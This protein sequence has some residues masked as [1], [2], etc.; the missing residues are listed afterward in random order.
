[1]S[2]H[3]RSPVW[4]ASRKAGLAALL[5]LQFAAAYAIGSGE[6][7]A[8]HQSSLFAPIAVTAFTPVALFLAA[9]GLSARFRGFVLAQD[10]RRITQMQQWRVVGFV[11]LALFAFEVLPGLFA[12]PAGVGDVAVGLMAL[13]VVARLERDPGF[14]TSAGFVGFHLLGLL[15]FTVAIVTAGL[16]AGAYPELISGG[17]TSAPMDVWPLN[18]F[19]S[20]IVPGFII[21]HLTALLKVRELRRVVREPA[22]GRLQAA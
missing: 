14:A 7:L 17:L 8:N 3:E 1:M 12:W 16:G 19:P 15:D 5:A 22:G 4:T 13:T 21:L 9:Y 10:L 2:T 6:L 11:F 18:I 20:F